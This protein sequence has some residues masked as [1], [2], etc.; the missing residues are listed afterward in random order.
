MALDPVTAALNIGG[1]LID[2]FFPDPQA[3]QEAQIKL[4]EMAQQGEFKALD[5]ELQMGLGQL[6]I[7]KAEAAS[8]SLFV[9]GWRPAV[10]WICVIGL[11][12]AFLAQ[13]MLEWY[14]G[15]KEFPAPPHMD[16]SVLITLLLGMLGLGGMRTTEKFKGVAR[17]AIN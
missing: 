17:G 16:L 14:S 4:M 12:Y 8:G 5:A 2:K 11:A 1:K 9:A 15:I 6:E 13:P 10:G 7:N 3:K